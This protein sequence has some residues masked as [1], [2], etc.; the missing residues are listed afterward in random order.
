LTAHKRQHDFGYDLSH[1]F[2]TRDVAPRR[3]ALLALFKSLC[4]FVKWRISGLGDDPAKFVARQNAELMQMLAVE[5]AIYVATC[6]LVIWQVKKSSVGSPPVADVIVA[7]IRGSEAV[8]VGFAEPLNKR[9]RTPPSSWVPSHS[10]E[11]S[12]C[13]SR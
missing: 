6:I 12:F 3:L 13:L 5:A 10:E 9:C 1:D 4:S 8:N 11:L 7:D 2:T